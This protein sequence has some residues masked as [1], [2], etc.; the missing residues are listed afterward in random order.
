MMA[1]AAAVLVRAHRRFARL[2]ER[3]AALERELRTPK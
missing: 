1:A 2:V 3:R